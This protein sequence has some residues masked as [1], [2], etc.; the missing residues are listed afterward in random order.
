MIAVN[1]SAGTIAVLRGLL[2]G[3]D[4]GPVALTIGL[5]EKENPAVGAPGQNLFVIGVYG[6]KYAARLLVKTL[7]GLCA[8]LVIFL[9]AFVLFFLFCFLFFCSGSKFNRSL[10]NFAQVFCRLYTHPSAAG[11]RLLKQ[12]LCQKAFFY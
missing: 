12:D 11:A 7:F 5:P 8:I 1:T 4:R 6:F 9:A 3:V 10:S 2:F